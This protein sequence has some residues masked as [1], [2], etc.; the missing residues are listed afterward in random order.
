MKMVR[1]LALVYI[2]T[3]HALFSITLKDPDSI[4][5]AIQALRIF[6][7]SH[8]S[9]QLSGHC[10]RKTTWKI[11]VAAYSL[12]TQSVRL[13]GYKAGESLQLV[14]SGEMISSW[15][16]QAVNGFGETWLTLRNPESL[17]RCQITFWI[18][19]PLISLTYQ[20]KM[21]LVHDW[22]LDPETQLVQKYYSRWI[23]SLSLA[24]G[25]HI[26][27]IKLKKVHSRGI[28]WMWEYHCSNSQKYMYNSSQ[29]V[30][31]VEPQSASL[32]GEPTHEQ[33]I[34][35]QDPW[36][37]ESPNNPLKD[38]PRASIS[39]DQIGCTTGPTGH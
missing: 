19:W 25:L 5:F 22:G 26:P 1:L 32:R 33:D 29:D 10:S 9:I 21:R 31:G 8:W 12:I 36:Q 7:I 34:N 3:E 30:V 24:V 14:T 2:T 20:L 11:A 13:T 17:H 28:V 38:F 16:T 27:E 6:T 39:E 35:N 23:H 15:Q 18:R 4:S 37:Q